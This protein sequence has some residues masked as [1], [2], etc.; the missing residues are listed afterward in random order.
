L[1]QLRRAPDGFNVR[2]ERRYRRYLAS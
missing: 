2:H 1:Q